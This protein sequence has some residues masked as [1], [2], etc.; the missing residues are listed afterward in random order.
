MDIMRSDISLGL[1]RLPMPTSADP[2]G[3]LK[4]VTMI[5]IPSETPC[6][7]VEKLSEAEAAGYIQAARDY[8]RRGSGCL[9]RKSSGLGN[10]VIRLSRGT[11]TIIGD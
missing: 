9:L 6:A 1:V 10:T 2:A 7:L 8:Q 5:L 11:N 3:T 4:A